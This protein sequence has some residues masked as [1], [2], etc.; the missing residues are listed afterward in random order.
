MFAVRRPLWQT[1][2]NFTML[3]YLEA[4][5]ELPRE[6]KGPLVRVLELFREDIAETV[7]KSDIERF[8]KTTEENFNRVWKSIEELAEAQKRT[9]QRLEQFEKA[10]EE[11]FNRVWKSI[12]ELAEAQKRTEKEIKMLTGELKDTRKMVGGLSDTVGYTLENEAYK[13]LPKLLARDFDIEVEGRLVRKYIEYPDGMHDE[14]NIFGKAKKNG[15]DLWVVGESKVRMSKR[16]INDFLKMVE[17][18]N[19]IIKRDKLLLGVT[20]TVMPDIKKYAQSKG[21]K[22]YWSYEF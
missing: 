16:E 8:E 10:T 7:K 20:H 13:A 19:S 9:E 1:C 22:V 11:N 17:R 15:N 6:L 4:I 2:Y 18:L 21:I 5:E 14:V 3:K 12:E